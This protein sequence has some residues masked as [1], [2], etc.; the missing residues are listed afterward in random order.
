MN[1]VFF[2][3]FKRIK[4]NGVFFMV[5]AAFSCLIFGP[6][7]DSCLRWLFFETSCELFNMIYKQTSILQFSDCDCY[8]ILSQPRYRERDRG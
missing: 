2:G 7:R 8:F 6:V 4:V 3:L 5:L 1:G